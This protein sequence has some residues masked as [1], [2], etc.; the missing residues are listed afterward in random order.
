V[1]PPE[2]TNPITNTKQP[3]MNPVTLSQAPVGQAK[4]DFL[5]AASV[6]DLTFT[7]PHDC[8]AVRVLQDT[9]TLVATE[10]HSGAPLSVKLEIERIDVPKTQSA[11]QV[12]SQAIQAQATQPQTQAKRSTAAS[13]SNPSHHPSHHPTNP[14]NLPNTSVRLLGHIEG[15]GDTIVQDQ[16]LGNPNSNARIEGFAIKVDGLPP[17]VKLVYGC[18]FVNAKIK[19]QVTNAGEFVGTRQKAQA[20]AAVLFALEGAGS[21]QY[22]LTGQVVFGTGGG[23]DARP[24]VVPLVAGGQLHGAGA[25]SH[26]VAINLQILA[27]S[28]ASDVPSQAPKQTLTQT[29]TQTIINQPDDIEDAQVGRA[30]DYHADA[31]GWQDDEDGAWTDDDIADVFGR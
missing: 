13:S 26:L 23:T 31:P 12:A 16:W 27:K 22:Q 29:P 15:V 2:Y 9:A 1:L 5:P 4:V 17:T 21:E 11:A 7:K 18:K 30:H 20:I 19:S 10:F 24:E 8:I 14:S 25:N 3:A 28:V 6:V